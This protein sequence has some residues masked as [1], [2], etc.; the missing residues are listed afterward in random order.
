MQRGDLIFGRKIILGIAVFIAAQRFSQYGLSRKLEQPL[1][2]RLNALHGIVGQKA[3]AY[4]PVFVLILI[5]KAGDFAFLQR[6]ALDGD[7]HAAQIM[8]DAFHHLGFADAVLAGNQ[9][10]DGEIALFRGQIC[11]QRALDEP[12]GFVD[13][14]HILIPFRRRNTSSCALRFSFLRQSFLPLVSTISASSCEK[15]LMKNFSLKS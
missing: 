15:C 13:A 5:R 12:F 11:E 14:N 9:R 1:L 8:G 3:K 10:R 2:L 4:L 6:A 7:A